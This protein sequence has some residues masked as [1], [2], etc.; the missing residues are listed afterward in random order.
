MKKSGRSRSRRLEV[1]DETNLERMDTTPPVEKKTPKQIFRGQIIDVLTRIK[2]GNIMTDTFSDKLAK[3]Y[4]DTPASRRPKFQEALTD[5]LEDCMKFLVK[6]NDGYKVMVLK[7]TC[8][9]NIFNFVIELLPKLIEME[10]KDEND[11]DS[12]LS[13][14][15]L[16]MIEFMKFMGHA[17]VRRKA[18]ELVGKMLD[19][20]NDDV[21]SE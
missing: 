9:E 13:Q 21:E 16:K 6:I 4:N 17:S 7:N 11:T 15:C 1:R 5:Q 20:V 18:I 3:I 2:D 8:L 12:V 19:L 14:V 10:G